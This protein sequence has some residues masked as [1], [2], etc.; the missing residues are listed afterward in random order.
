MYYPFSA[1]QRKGGTVN[2]LVRECTLL[3]E[4]L[5]FTS[6]RTMARC[7]TYVGNEG[8]EEIY[9]STLLFHQGSGSTYYVRK[10]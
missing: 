9:N 1:E 5:L 7:L 3:P 4:D 6:G 8:F 2:T 10:Q